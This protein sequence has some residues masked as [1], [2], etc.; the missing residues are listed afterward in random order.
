M[1]A[2]CDTPI[3][4]KNQTTTG[5]F[6]LAEHYNEAEQ[7]LRSGHSQTE[8]A[9]RFGVTQAAIS[10]AISRGRIKH[11]TGVRRLLPWKNVKQEHLRL[12]VPRQLRAAM[13]LVAGDTQPPIVES[14]AR[15]FIDELNR[16][17]AVIHYDP[18]VAPYW[19]RVP[20]RPGI[21]NGLV[22]EPDN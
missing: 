16:M 18:D 2:I 10:M 3:M 5:G 7:L 22:R 11:E 4:A 9:E 13:H 17:D 6:A 21:D 19:F 20:R 14:Q 8:V 12:N 15:R 1:C